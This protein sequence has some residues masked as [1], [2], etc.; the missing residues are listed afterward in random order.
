MYVSGHA[1]DHREEAPAGIFRLAATESNVLHFS[2][3]NGS[4]CPCILACELF[5]AAEL[6]ST[7]LRYSPF[8]TPSACLTIWFAVLA[9]VFQYG[10]R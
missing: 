2:H 7:Y 6:V 9:T 4:R 5:D 8:S 3:P 10:L 1:T